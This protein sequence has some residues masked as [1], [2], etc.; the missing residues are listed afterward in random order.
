MGF[1]VG[2]RVVV[3]ENY[4]GAGCNREAVGYYGHVAARAIGPAPVVNGKA[5]L[6]VSLKGRINGLPVLDHYLDHDGT[7]PFPLYEDELEHAD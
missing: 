3:T 7:D 6:L 4:R 5:M 2:D 1:V